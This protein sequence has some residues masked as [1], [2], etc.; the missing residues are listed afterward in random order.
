[1]GGHS[2]LFLLSSSRRY[3]RVDHMTRSLTKLHAEEDEELASYFSSR[4]SQSQSQCNLLDQED[5]RRVTKHSGVND[6]SQRALPHAQGHYQVFH[7]EKPFQDIA[8]PGHLESLSE[9]N[10]FTGEKWA[11]PREQPP[12]T[13]L[14]RSPSSYE[15][16]QL[17][18][19]KQNVVSGRGYSC[20][21]SQSDLHLSQDK[22]LTNKQNNDCDSNLYQVQSVSHEHY[23]P[24]TFTREPRRNRNSFHESSHSFADNSGTSTASS[25]RYSTDCGKWTPSDIENQ[26]KSLSGSLTWKKPKDLFSQSEWNKEN[27]DSENGIYQVSDEQKGENQGGV[28]SF[29]NLSKQKNN[30]GSAINIVYMHQDHESDLGTYKKPTRPGYLHINKSH[31]SM[32]GNSPTSSHAN[33]SDWIKCND[34]K[35]QSVTDSSVAA[36]MHDIRLK[37]EEKRKRIEHEKALLE[38][39]SKKQREKMGKAAFMQAVKGGSSSA[40]NRDDF[41]SKNRQFSVEDLSDELDTVRR[42]WLERKNAE[43]FENEIPS[44]DIQMSIE[45]L[46]SSLSDLQ[47]DISRLTEQQEMIQKLLKNNTP[48]QNDIQ[49]H[50]P[51]DQNINS[52]NKIPS[53]WAE[54]VNSFQ[55]NSPMYSQN[56]MPEIAPHIGSRG[57]W[58][59][60]VI[61]FGGFPQQQQQQPQHQNIPMWQQSSHSVRSSSVDPQMMYGQPMNMSSQMYD[62]VPF[63]QGFS[64]HPQNMPSSN[65]NNY[66]PSSSYYSNEPQTNNIHAQG[67][68]PYSNFQQTNYPVMQ[69]TFTRS[70][71]QGLNRSD[72]R[73][74]HLH[75]NPSE[76]YLADV[77]DNYPRTI[78]HSPSANQF[79][80]Y[81]SNSASDI[82][83]HRNNALEVS[84]DEFGRHVR[85]SELQHSPPNR[86]V[87]GKTF[88]V[89]KSKVASPT[90]P[91]YKQNP[92]FGQSLP[93]EQ[94]EMQEQTESKTNTENENQPKDKGFYISFEEEPRKPKPKLKPKHLKAR[95]QQ[96][97]I[98]NESRKA[99]SCNEQSHSNPN[100]E[101]CFRK[102]WDKNSSEDN[103]GELENAKQDECASETS[104]QSSETSHSCPPPNSSVGFVVGPGPVEND[105]DKELEM[106]RRKEMIMMMSLRRRAEQEKKKNEQQ[107]EYLKKRDEERLKREQQEK[108][109]EEEKLRRQLILEQYRQRKAQEEEDATSGGHTRGREE[110]TAASR[111]AT[112]TRSKS[113][114]A[115][116]TRPR[117]RSGQSNSR[118]QTL[119]SPS[120]LDSPVNRGS[121]FNLSGGYPDEVSSEHGYAPSPCRTR[122]Y[123]H[124]SPISPTSYPSSPGPLLSGILGGNSFRNRST[125]SD[126]LS[127]SSSTVSSAWASEYS[128]PKLFVKPS[129]KSNRNIVTNAVNT[130]L[131][132]AVNSETKKKVVEEIE[133]SEGK[134]FLI[135]FRDAGC[136]FRALYSYNP[137]TEEVIKLYGIGPRVITEKM[138]DRFYKY[139]SGGKSFT[140]IHTKHLTATIDAFTIQNS[141]WQGKKTTVA[142]KRDYY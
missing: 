122:N 79:D 85:N 76:P 49:S 26:N 115:S 103:T 131:A 113:R 139:N 134:H 93:E 116:V 28:M 97:K 136:Q 129:A 70:M 14:Q 50:F 72:S 123:P 56:V 135:L 126:G 4:H 73:G 29:A 47:F 25:R 27:V 31:P 77:P 120:S 34:N 51:H 30:S 8:S 59:Q 83:N 48:P 102:R 33:S 62:N 128:G 88:R 109:K 78:T 16:H 5:N 44:D 95:N 9:N 74:F 100:T 119:S 142:P 112:M 138:F 13:N 53:K 52:Q 42:K 141:L 101:T 140:Q 124:S 90:S 133:R 130:V 10:E 80:I 32:D 104:E 15:I 12:K 65:Y 68:Y 39:L 35:N 22:K 81:P 107:Q 121:Q 41:Y 94:P 87:L 11:E 98:D 40:L 17:S 63:N 54:P 84:T 61:P 125:P 67:Q 18:P 38:K 127:D 58:G 1:M 82:M 117:Q 23:S 46:N 137:E 64:L 99:E 20:Q 91:N 89:N 19:S 37:L 110:R 45:Q 36:Q 86:P 96:K 75:R 106:T 21:R 71:S 3:V 111:G 114:S 6:P 132:G 43:D 55:N 69:N 57:H 60:P 118:S 66:Y 92:S 105:P 108:K 7:S 2:K 24:R